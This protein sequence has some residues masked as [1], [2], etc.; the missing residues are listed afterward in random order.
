MEGPRYPPV[1]DAPV[2][3][4]SSLPATPYAY[5]H[6]IHLDPPPPYEQHTDS[7]FPAPSPPLGN[8]ERKDH[9]HKFFFARP[10]SYD[11]S[12]N[13]S[14]ISSPAE[15]EDDVSAEDSES[16]VEEPSL[17]EN[18]PVVTVQDANFDVE[19]MTEDDIGYGSDTEVVFPDGV[20]EA[21]GTKETRDRNGDDAGISG[22]F[23]EMNCEDESIGA[24]EDQRHRF[25][26]RKKR[27]SGRLF[28]RT[29]SQ[30]IG[31][32]TD[33]ADLDGLGSYEAGS[34]ARRLRR[35]LNG[36]PGDR[37]SLI[38]EDLGDSYT[39]PEEQEHAHGN[40]PSM[41]PDVEGSHSLPFWVLQDP[42]DVDSGS[43]G[44]PSSA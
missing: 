25:E 29:H 17:Q 6:Y 40:G 18:K 34:S 21:T 44:P 32:D 38:F 26:R 13:S 42:M 1:F 28:K 8:A 43:S 19:E 4:P 33:D 10:Q 11:S 20:E 31:S 41:P 15:M 12:E 2:H 5:P 9:G 39:L 27:W 30:S 14:T 37:S 35:K 3:Q 7:L 24:G 36:G 23:E 16:L 22:K